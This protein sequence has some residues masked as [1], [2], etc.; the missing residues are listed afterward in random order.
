MNWGNPWFRSRREIYSLPVQCF[1]TNFTEMYSDFSIEKHL[2]QSAVERLLPGLAG[3]A[4]PMGKA[5]NSAMVQFHFANHHN[6]C[7]AGVTRQCC[8]LAG[9][10]IFFAM[11]S[12]AASVICQV[13]ESK[14]S[15]LGGI[16]CM[17]S[18]VLEENKGEESVGRGR[19]QE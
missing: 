6:E 18:N 5:I 16:I 11:K 2:G 14:I 17:V 15:A 9:M 7:A 8:V 3:G 4:R 1:G 13:L 12:T 19:G 10:A